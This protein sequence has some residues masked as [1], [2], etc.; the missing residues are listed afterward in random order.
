MTMKRHGR[1]PKPAPKRP[2]IDPKS[3]SDFII[4][5]DTRPLPP[6]DLKKLKKLE[7]QRRRDVI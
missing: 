2:T 5:R 4:T 6:P 1:I 7:Y 3:E